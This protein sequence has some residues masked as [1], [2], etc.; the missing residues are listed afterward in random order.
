M[1]FVPFCFWQ[2]W[3]VKAL[4]KISAVLLKYSTFRGVFVIFHGQN[5]YKIR[6]S[7][8]C[9]VHTKSFINIKMRKLDIFVSACTPS[10]T[11]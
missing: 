4:L 10:N 6:V 7:V 8:R 2:I 5:N 9:N 11:S 3:V 1:N